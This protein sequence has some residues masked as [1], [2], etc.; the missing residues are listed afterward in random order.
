METILAGDI[1][2][3]KTRLALFDA[4][5]LQEPRYMK[6]YPSGEYESLRAI[7]N[8]FIRE[9]K[10]EAPEAVPGRAGFG[11]AGPV[12]GKTVKL[13]NL[14]WEIDSDLIADLLGIG[15][16]VFVNDFYANSLAVPLLRP[17][18]VRQIGTGKPIEQKPIAVLGAGTGLGE[19]FLV[20]SGEGYLVLP[21]EGGHTDFAPRTPQEIRLLEFLTARF[22]RVSYE[23]VLSGPGLINIYQFFRERENMV[24]STA[25]REA[26][27]LDDAAAVISRRGLSRSDPICERALDL[28][29]SLYGAEAGNLAL[30]CLTTGGVFLAGGIA[31]KIA[32][33]L[34]EGGFRHGFEHKGRFSAFLETVPTFVITHP[35]LGLM[36]AAVAASKL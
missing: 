15:K 21:S 14:P 25:V 13:T 22:N 18:D 36:G 2:G 28:F 29:C 5:R 10:E 1:G 9:A 31:A 32:D 4:E 30:K 35:H 20:W 16:V 7:V 27:V 17:G 24:E 6:T 26:M 3:T 34:A 23:R 19:G 8:R 33:R 11:V 12:D